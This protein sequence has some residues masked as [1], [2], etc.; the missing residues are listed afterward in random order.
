MIVLYFIGTEHM[1]P[2]QYPNLT[3]INED[4]NVR[5]KI[6]ILSQYI[7][8]KIPRDETASITIQ[9]IQTAVELQFNT[10]VYPHNI[11]AL[12][13]DFLL[14]VHPPSKSAEML[15]TG[16][17][18]MSPISPILIPWHSEYGCIKIPADT[19]LANIQVC[20]ITIQ[21]LKA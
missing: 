7:I 16:Y 15:H 18:A 20:L 8:A 19:Q 10:Q 2:Y 6:D 11:S 9:D 5:M 1:E 21:F 12:R 4:E 3:I 14:F 17:I 13:S